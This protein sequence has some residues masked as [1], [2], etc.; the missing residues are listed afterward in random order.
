MIQIFSSQ[1]RENNYQKNYTALHREECWSDSICP[2]LFVCS[3]DLIE[4]G[5]KELHLGVRHACFPWWLIRHMH[6]KD[7]GKQMNTLVVMC[8]LRVLDLIPLLMHVLVHRPLH[9]NGIFFLVLLCMLAI[10]AAAVLPSCSLNW[11]KVNTIV[12]SLF[13]SP[14]LIHTNQERKESWRGQCI[15][16]H[17][18]CSGEVTGPASSNSHIAILDYEHRTLWSKPLR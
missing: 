14:K 3:G 5:F 18:D 8:T 4:V 6:N 13:M 1:V 11:F 17:L 16:V 7:R 15:C 9:A 12:M 10:W 2:Y